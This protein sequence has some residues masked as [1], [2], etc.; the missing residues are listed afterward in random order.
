DGPVSMNGAPARMPPTPGASPG[1]G[2]PAPR[3]APQP[4]RESA[5][6]FE[7]EKWDARRSQPRPQPARPLPTGQQLPPQ[8]QTSGRMP[9]RMTPEQIAAAKRAAQKR[10][11]EAAGVHSANY[12]P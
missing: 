7:D 12:Q 1:S 9:Q 10:A 5:G 3:T 11:Y 8:F 2:M 6:I 4:R